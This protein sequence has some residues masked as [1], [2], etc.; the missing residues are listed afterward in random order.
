MNIDKKEVN[1]LVFRTKQGDD[2]AFER[3]YL[4]LKL[5]LLKFVNNLVAD[6]DVADDI[7]Q[8]VFFR[9]VNHPIKNFSN[10]FGWMFTVARNL[11]FNYLHKSKFEMADSAASVVFSENEYV[12]SD[13]KI[14]LKSYLAKLDAADRRLLVLK[15]AAR[16]TFK[17][18]SDLYGFSESA[19]K[20][21]IKKILQTLRESIKD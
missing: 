10:C 11:A 2:A 6:K 19:I 9:V 18:L 21:K 13:E 8:S 5:P 20:R 15:Y 7:V 17:D 3:L 14:D 16:F 1:D 4:L 12:W